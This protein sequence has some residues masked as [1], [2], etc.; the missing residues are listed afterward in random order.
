MLYCTLNPVTALTVGK[1]KANAQVL[2]GTVITGA[3]GK[4]TTHTVD[5]LVQPLPSL[6]VTV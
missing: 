5:V 3:V 2:T 1:V 4:T 6:P